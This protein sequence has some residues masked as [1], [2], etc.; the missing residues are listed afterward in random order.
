[1]NSNTTRTAPIIRVSGTAATARWCRATTGGRYT[2]PD[3][4]DVRYVT[5]APNV[6][7]GK[8]LH[9]MVTGVILSLRPSD[10]QETGK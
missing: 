9:E 6:P 10:E 4:P 3:P 5:I 7:G 1:M 2:L 8:S